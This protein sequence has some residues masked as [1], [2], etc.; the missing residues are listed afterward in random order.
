[1]MQDTIN[2]NKGKNEIL[3]MCACSL[4]NYIGYFS[5]VISLKQG[6]LMVVNNH[7]GPL[8]ILSHYQKKIEK[9]KKTRISTFR[10][11]KN[12]II[13]CHQFASA[14]LIL[15]DHL[16]K[17]VSKID[18]SCMIY[19]ENHRL[20]LVNKSKSVAVFYS[21][22]SFFSIFSISSRKLI[23]RVAIEEGL[24]LISC[25]FMDLDKIFVL[26]KEEDED[27]YYI[28]W[29]SAYTRK[30]RLLAIGDEIGD[31]SEVVHLDIAA[32]A[33]DNTVIL[34]Y[35]G[36]RNKN[37]PIFLSKIRILESEEDPEELEME[38]L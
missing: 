7:N 18:G 9:N 28:A 12:G 25:A 2:G 34:A 23:S 26:T 10:E 17:I 38:V 35:K 16:G 27:L 36:T 15:L 30:C 8:Q 5:N 24:D 33:S 20:L 32:C 6:S 22:A 31:A 37:D 11:G 13:L 19:D 4:L 21:G 3:N 29:I 1:M 14:D